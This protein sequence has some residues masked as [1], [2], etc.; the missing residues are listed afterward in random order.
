MELIH[1]VLACSPA[2]RKIITN[3]CSLTTDLK[4]DRELEISQ[5]N[6]RPPSLLHLPPYL[7]YLPLLYPKPFISNIIKDLSTTSSAATLR[8]RKDF[9]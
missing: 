5:L 1:T 7:L 9:I 2:F 6:S 4:I 8:M 3:K